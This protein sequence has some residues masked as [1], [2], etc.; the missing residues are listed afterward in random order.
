MASTPKSTT[1]Q[2]PTVHRTVR[3]R[4][5]PG[6]AET[7]NRLAGTAGACRFVYNRLLGEQNRLY[8]MW[9]SLH[10]PALRWPEVRG[11]TTEWGR[12]QR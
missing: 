8:A 11:R 6:D 2:A 1:E 3:V 7:G 12:A 10:V 4:L 5:Y 9:R